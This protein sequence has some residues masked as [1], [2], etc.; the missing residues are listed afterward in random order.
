MLQY[1]YDDCNAAV[2]DVGAQRVEVRQRQQLV[3]R[4]AR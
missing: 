1:L 3:A 2:N 4:L